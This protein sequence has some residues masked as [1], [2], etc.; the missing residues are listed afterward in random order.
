MKARKRAAEAE[1]VVVNHHLFFAD[2]A[3]RD[4]GAADLL[5]SANT[6][7]FDEAHHLP[8]LAR[9]FFG[10]SIS[11]TQL[12]EL[13]RDIRLPAAEPARDTPQLGDAASPLE[14]AA[15]DL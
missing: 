9:L 3:L 12:L 6:L 1:V 14:R 13:A 2:L 4:E 7:I 15:R 8:D 5:G 11:T 10:Q